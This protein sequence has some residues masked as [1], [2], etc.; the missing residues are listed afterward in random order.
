MEMEERYGAKSTFYFMASEEDPFRFRYHIEDLKSRLISIV[1]EGWEIGLHGSYYAY[2]DPAVIQ[3]E[4]RRLE[5]VLG[6]RIIGYRNHYLKFQIPDTWEYLAQAGF[7]YDTTFGF[8]DAIGFRSGLYH[9]FQ[10]YNP[11]TDS[12]INILEIPL[13]IMDSAL[14]DLFKSPDQAWGPIKELV[15]TTEKCNGVLTVLWHNNSFNNPIRDGYH[16]LYE[17]LLKYG[18]QKNAWMTSGEEI[19]R[20]W[21]DGHW[22][23]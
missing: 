22:N 4:K 18:R 8:N 11:L 5:D 12:K 17:R 16:Q 10:P 14:L 1:N 23:H 19:W 7:K 13:N 9:P 15:D 20:W 21:H 6:R 2:R 3:R